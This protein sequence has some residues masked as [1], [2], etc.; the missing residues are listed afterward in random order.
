[1]TTTEILLSI[2]VCALMIC[3]GHIGGYK[4]RKREEEPGKISLIVSN[5]EF[6][7]MLKQESG[8]LL[9]VTYKADLATNI[10]IR[11]VDTKAPN[12]IIKK[13]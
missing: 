2:L 13:S 11:V 3:I 1:M 4:T 12:S 5:K 9:A 8:N 10:E 6:A 7:E